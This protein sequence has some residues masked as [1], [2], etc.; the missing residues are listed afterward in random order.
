MPAFGKNFQNFT[1]LSAGYI[2]VP[3]SEK[4]VLT[5]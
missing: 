2:L 3:T 4:R 5:N 1:V